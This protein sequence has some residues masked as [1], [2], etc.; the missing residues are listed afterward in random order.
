MAWL[1][2]V[3]WQERECIAKSSEVG[4][5]FITVDLSTTCAPDRSIRRL[6]VSYDLRLTATKGSRHDN[7][8]KMRRSRIKAGRRKAQW[9]NWRF[10]R[11][12]KPNRQRKRSGTVSQVRAAA[13]RA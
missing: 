6:P 11:N 10:G 8:C 5:T 12:W 13:G 4:C 1:E 7:W 2:V 3:P 9:E